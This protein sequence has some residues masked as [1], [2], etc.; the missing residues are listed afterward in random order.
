[1]HFMINLFRHCP[2]FRQKTPPVKMIMLCSHLK[3]WILSSKNNKH[4]Y[5]PPKIYIL[6]KPRISL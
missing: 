6:R 1:M 2:A 4:R 3:M 5:L